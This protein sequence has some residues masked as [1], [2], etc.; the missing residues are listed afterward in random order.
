MAISHPSI[1]PSVRPFLH[2]AIVRS[3]VPSCV[4]TPI[5][6]ACHVDLPWRL[7]LHPSRPTFASDGPSTPLFD[8]V[9]VS[10]RW[11]VLSRHV[12]SNLGSGEAPARRTRAVG[13]VWSTCTCFVPPTRSTQYPW[14]EREIQ[15]LAKQIFSFPPVQG[16][17]R[18]GARHLTS[19]LHQ[20]QRPTTTYR[21]DRFLFPSF[22][23]DRI[24]CPT[25]V[26]VHGESSASDAVSFPGGIRHP[27]SGCLVL[28][29]KSESAP[30]P[31]QIG[32]PTR[33]LCSPPPFP[34]R[35]SA[36]YRCAWG[37]IRS[38][39]RTLREKERRGQKP[40][41]WP[42]RVRRAPRRHNRPQ[43]VEDNTRIRRR[44]RDAKQ[45]VERPLRKRKGA[46]LR[47]RRRLVLVLRLG[48]R[49]P[50]R[51]CR[52]R[53]RGWNDETKAFGH[54]TCKAR[55]RNVHKRLKGGT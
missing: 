52:R 9:V 1:H 8:H 5:V 12:L 33:S 48:R 2:L 17:V 51:T 49:C 26:R 39:R 42:E 16:G 3:S 30:I 45:S 53:K 28:S 19:F 6:A 37:S 44:E 41:R 4:R 31:P 24:F 38:P 34:S 11:Q 25:F 14:G 18:R 47:D 20:R 7:A 27:H 36:R 15:S 50:G 40:K 10:F 23:K 32:A 55:K 21:T 46:H 35:S 43:A 13:L 54:E 22:A 29:S